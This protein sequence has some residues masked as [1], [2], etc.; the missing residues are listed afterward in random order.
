[1]SSAELT[2][3]RA[4]VARAGFEPG[5]VTKASVRLAGLAWRGRILKGNDPLPNDI[6][7]YLRHTA[8][9]QEWPLG[10]TF[11]AYLA[12]LRDAIL[13]LDG[14]VYLEQISGIWISSFLG[15]SASNRGPDGGRWI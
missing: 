11:A 9:N 1:A 13:N 10:T 3:I 14:G 6:A 7:H 5:S 4:H 12:S 2:Q 8:R 15:P